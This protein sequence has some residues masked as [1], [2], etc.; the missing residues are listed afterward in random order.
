M[1]IEIGAELQQQQHG[2]KELEIQE[3]LEKLKKELRLAVNK[4]IPLLVQVDES[5]QVF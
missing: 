5:F 4:I 3:W 1:H 2:E